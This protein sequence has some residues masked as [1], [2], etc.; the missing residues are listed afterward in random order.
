[1]TALLSRHHAPECSQCGRDEPACG[2]DAVAVICTHC[3]VGAAVKAQ[4]SI[5]DCPGCG[6]QI[7][8]DLMR[9]SS[10]ERKAHLAGRMQARARRYNGAR[11]LS[12]AGK[13]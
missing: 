1:M 2:E 11:K 4:E 10:C 9:C 3:T 13:E 12:E 6:K 8:G 7:A 5:K